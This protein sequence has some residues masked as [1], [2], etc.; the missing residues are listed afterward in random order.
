MLTTET[1]EL[2]QAL[3]N[4]CQQRRLW[5]R[6]IFEYGCGE[7][8]SADNKYGYGNITCRFGHVEP[9]VMGNYDLNPSSSR[10]MTK[11]PR[12]SSIKQID[13]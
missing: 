3:Q 7:A 8:A 10:T 2:A 11:T 5:K 12:R 4:K 1:V 13:P 6:S 9:T